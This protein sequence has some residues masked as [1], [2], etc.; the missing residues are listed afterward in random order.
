MAL[1]KTHQG[2]SM[3]PNLINKALEFFSKAGSIIG[4]RYYVVS[5]DIHQDTKTTW[6]EIFIS[7]PE[8]AFKL[9]FWSRDPRGGA[10][11]RQ[12]LRE[13]LHEVA[14]ESA[15]ARSWIRANLE[16]IVEYGRYDDLKALYDTPLET[17]VLEFFSANISHPLCAKWMDRRDRKLRD[18]MKLTSKEYR[19]LVVGNS[20]IVERLMSEKRWDEIDYVTLPNL[21]MI[22]SAAAFLRHDSERFLA[23]IRDHGLVGTV[24]F[25]H[26]M[27]RLHKA[28]TPVEIVQSFFDHL[29]DYIKEGERI[30]PMVDV[31]G[32]MCAEA[33]GSISCMDVSVS[34]GLY[35]S[36]RLPG[37]FNKKM[38]TFAS[39]PEIIDWSRTNNV[40]EAITQAVTA[41]WGMSTDISKALDCILKNAEL[42]NV[43]QSNMPTMLLVL[44]DMQFSQAVR[45]HTRTFEKGPHKTILQTE[46]SVIDAALQRWEDSGY[47]RPA[48]VYWNLQ[49]YA[50]QPSYTS[51][52]VAFIS[53]FSPAIME[54]VLSCIERDETGEVTKL[55]AE[56]VMETAISKYQVADPFAR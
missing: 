31:S 21:A 1:F 55:D 30:L 29:P 23:H 3:A 20:N 47:K 6:A 11:H 33:S 9:L 34:L 13:L 46:E 36:D 52:N 41:D 2:G 16:G 7:D 10:G 54:A 25:P 51:N 4:Q 37:Q 32:S 38:M 24:A 53:G 12:L 15:A 45:S 44:S 19:K 50:G 48:I 49:N 43:P 40:V 28:G 22:R 18:Y 26:E 35:C 42:W 39:E 8:K 56:V 17:A 5:E 14:I 27:M